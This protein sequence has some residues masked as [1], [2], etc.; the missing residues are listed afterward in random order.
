[1]A[2]RVFGVA[3]VLVVEE[4]DGVIRVF[5]REIDIELKY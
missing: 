4:E 1:M 2:K 5:I 3:E